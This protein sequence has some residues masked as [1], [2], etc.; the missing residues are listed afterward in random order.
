MARTCSPF[1]KLVSIRGISLRKS[2]RRCA[3]V[4]LVVSPPVETAE[5][6]EP[7][8][9]SRTCSRVEI[10][11][12]EQRVDERLLGLLCGLWVPTPGSDG[13]VVMGEAMGI[14]WPMLARLRGPVYWTI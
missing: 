5:G 8:S 1:N 9:G 3:S 12:L 2:P 11:R 14:G 6:Y 7:D 10:D 4:R 13:G